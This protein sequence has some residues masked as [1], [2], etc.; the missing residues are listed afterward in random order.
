MAAL[1]IVDVQEIRDPEKYEEYKK[2]TPGAIAEFDG[3]F[4][5][6]GGQCEQIEGNY[7]PSRCVIIEFPSMEKL[8]AFYSSDTY[9]PA[10]AIRTA[11]STGNAYAVETV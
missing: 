5:V 7:L 10:L 9:A 2:L 3:R 8:K 1:M 4:L 6:R 11:I